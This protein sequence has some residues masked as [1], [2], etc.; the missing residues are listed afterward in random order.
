MTEDLSYPSNQDDEEAKYMGLCRLGREGKMRRI[1][2]SFCW[3]GSCCSL[4]NFMVTLFRYPHDTLSPARGRIDILCRYDV[5]FPLH[6]T[7]QECPL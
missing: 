2:A 5:H 3:P 6:S 7:N 4:V 1:G